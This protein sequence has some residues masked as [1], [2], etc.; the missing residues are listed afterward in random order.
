MVI[1]IS[2]VTYRKGYGQRLDEVKCPNL[3]TKINSI[4]EWEHCTFPPKVKE[5][6]DDEW[7][8]DREFLGPNPELKVG[9]AFKF[10]N[11]LL[12]IEDE[13]TMV[14]VMSETGIGGLQRVWKEKISPEFDIVFGIQPEGAEFE[15]ADS[16]EIPQDWEEKRVPY[17]VMRLLKDRMVPGRGDK[18]FKERG[19]KVKVTLHSSIIMFPIHLILTDWGFWYDPNELEKDEL[20]VVAKELVS[21][22][23]NKF[24]RIKTSNENPYEKRNEAVREAKKISGQ[25]IQQLDEAISRGKEALDEA[26]GVK[27]E[28]SSAADEEDPVEPFKGELYFKVEKADNLG[29]FKPETFLS[30]SDM[31]DLLRDSGYESFFSKFEKDFPEYEVAE[32]M[33]SVF[34]VLDAGTENFADEHILE[35]KLKNHP[36]YKEGTWC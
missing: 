21:V 10:G 9:S 4:L 30:L 29:V 34:E 12:A 6:S 16:E 26:A 5:G 22:L 27:D 28:D 8:E 14:L 20:D 36:D 23:Y 19:T 13:D 32:A 17:E 1:E 25:M 2:N 15:N 18:M 24:P 31:P 11:Q 7:I 3:L 35:D 33:E